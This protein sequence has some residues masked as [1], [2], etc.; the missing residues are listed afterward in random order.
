M[1]TCQ[2]RLGL[3]NDPFRLGPVQTNLARAA[4]SYLQ[5]NN[6]NNLNNNNLRA[7]NLNPEDGK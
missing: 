5:D 3:L 4:L 6:N 2:V 7:G 1:N